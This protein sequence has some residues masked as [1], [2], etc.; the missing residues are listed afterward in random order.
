MCMSVRARAHSDVYGIGE[1]PQSWDVAIHGSSGIVTA[2]ADSVA[3]AMERAGAQGVNLDIAISSLDREQKKMQEIC[4][5]V[6][7]ALAE[8]PGC[9][10][11][12]GGAEAKAWTAFAL[13]I[14]GYGTT[15]GSSGAQLIVGDNALFR[16]IALVSNAS[17][18]LV[19][20]INTRLLKQVAREEKMRTL[21]KAVQQRAKTELRTITN[22]LAFYKAANKQAEQEQK[23][24][25][26][27]P[28]P[29]ER[30]SSAAGVGFADLVR[31]VATAK[32]MGI[33]APPPPED[34]GAAAP[35][36][37]TEQASSRRFTIGEDK[38]AAAMDEV[39]ENLGEREIQMWKAIA[40]GD[41]IKDAVTA[42]IEDRG[43]DSSETNFVIPAQVL[44]HQI[45]KLSA[46][47]RV[48][49]GELSEPARCIGTVSQQDAKAWGY[50]VV[51]NI[52]W[53]GG[54]GLT[55]VQSWDGFNEYLA[56][57]ATGLAAVRGGLSWTKKKLLE[58]IAKEEAYRGRMQNLREIA[59]AAIHSFEA[60][61]RSY[62]ADF[63]KDV[64]LRSSTPAEVATEMKK[65][66]EEQRTVSPRDRGVSRQVY[67]RRLVKSAQE[68][69]VDL[70]T[71][72][73]DGCLAVERDRAVLRTSPDSGLRSLGS[74]LSQPG[75]SR[76]A[77]GPAEGSDPL[78]LSDVE[79]VEERESPPASHGAA[80]PAGSGQ[81]SGADAGAGIELASVTVDVG[82][83]GAGR[84]E[85]GD[86]AGAARPAGSGTN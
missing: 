76:G 58:E 81:S 51:E 1:T 47:L 67:A 18:G 74:T 44:A 11:G 56:V 69:G 64:S 73:L 10:G 43:G 24:G 41:A 39:P 37:V 82:S 14:V 35:A 17:E 31:M 7:A 34:A 21:L 84:E 46:I 28:R 80:A 59:Q 61:L 2:I 53:V 36:V 63:A 83:A 19:S 52:T 86:G 38:V 62:V 54:L 29:V 72:P 65:A 12:K 85:G 9:C 30:K 26:A 50:W 68:R 78:S 23:A 55:V 27:T 42:D 5:L 49:D 57:S 66:L 79:D 3:D 20:G 33:E 15:L 77:S 16:A 70:T 32:K 48:I 8:T 75:H 13:E 6:R 22:E 71:L 45:T 25:A 60:T 4:R 40:A